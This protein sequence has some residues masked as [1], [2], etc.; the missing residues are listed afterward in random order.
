MAVTS[1]PIF[2]ASCFTAF[3]VIIEFIVPTEVAIETLLNNSLDSIRSVS[4]IFM[5]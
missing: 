3:V 2:K 5:K 1:E 4:N